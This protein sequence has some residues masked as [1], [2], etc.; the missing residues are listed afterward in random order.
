[1]LVVSP[2][3]VDPE[4]SRRKLERQV[5]EFQNNAARYRERGYWIAFQE[6]LNVYVAAAARIPMS[7]GP[8]PFPVVTACVRFNFDNFDLWAPSLTIVDFFT[9]QPSFPLVGAMEFAEGEPLNLLIGQHPQTQLPF[10]CL[11]GVR[12]YHTHPQH[13]G[14]LWLLRRSIT[15]LSSLAEQVWML[16][17]RNVVGIRLELARNTAGVN[18]SLQLVQAKM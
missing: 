4:I 2:Q 14:D 3:L 16:M 5:K 8:I 15:S 7:I 17:A 9:L 6:G 11:P 12:E 10:L 1:M 13:T 18:L